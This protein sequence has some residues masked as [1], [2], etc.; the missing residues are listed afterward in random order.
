MVVLILVR[1]LVVHP[2]PH[3]SQVP[4]EFSVLDNYSAVLIGILQSLRDPTAPA[5]LPSSVS[6]LINKN[7]QFLLK[8]MINF[9]CNF[10]NFFYNKDSQFFELNLVTSSSCALLLI[11]IIDR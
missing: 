5:F 9:H 2:R 1:T 10:L 6:I 7:C 3:S 11:H 8:K 4:A